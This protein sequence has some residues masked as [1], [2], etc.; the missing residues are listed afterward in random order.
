M[1]WSRVVGVVVLAGLVLVA[2]AAGTSGQGLSSS[3]RADVEQAVSEFYQAL[4]ARAWD[5]VKTV[6]TPGLAARIQS[7]G[8]ASDILAARVERLSVLDLQVA[9]EAARA[10]VAIEV[11]L[12]DGTRDLHHHTVDLLAEDTW[13]VTG[14][15]PAV[16]LP[17]GGR[18]APGDFDPAALGRYVT[19]VGRG[20][21]DRAE[22]E[23]VGQARAAHRAGRL[24]LGPNGAGLFSTATEPEIT[25]LAADPDLVLALARYQVDGR[26]VTLRV[27]FARTAGG[28]RVADVQAL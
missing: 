15:A 23:L 25:V 6:T 22:R 14:V 20:E 12:A 17:S 13:R 3:Q 2:V 18:E 26:P 8:Q 16:P 21:W 9:G 24:A 11:E 4:A 7:Q 1:R 27:L 10:V 19:A 28:W 5:R